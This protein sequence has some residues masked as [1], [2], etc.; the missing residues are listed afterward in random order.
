[1]RSEK[2]STKQVAIFLEHLIL[3]EYLQ[4][5]ITKNLSRS[6]CPLKL[7]KKNLNNIVKPINKRYGLSQRQIALGFKVHYSTTWGNLRRQ[8]SIVIRKR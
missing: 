6:G 7:S 4:N 2:I 3:K 8:T 5:E 1:M